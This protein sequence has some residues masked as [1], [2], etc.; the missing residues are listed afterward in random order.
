MSEEVIVFTFN[1]LYWIQGFNNQDCRGMCV[2]FNSL[3]WI[4]E[5]ARIVGSDGGVLSI[6]CIG[7]KPSE[8]MSLNSL[9]LFQFFVL[10]SQ[11]PDILPSGFWSKSFQF[12]VLDS[13]STPIGR[14]TPITQTFNS[15][16]WIQGE[17][18]ESGCMDEFDYLSILCIGFT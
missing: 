1:S 10:D 4:R 15:L 12:F 18:K 5:N 14:L 9:Q 13:P 7:F 3:Y 2:S 8:T 17:G 16:Y 6:L 11:Y